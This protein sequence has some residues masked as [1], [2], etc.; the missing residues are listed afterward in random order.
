MLNY[1]LG[2]I[3]TR[4]SSLDWRHIVVVKNIGDMC[5]VSAQ[6][7]ECGYLFPLYLYDADG[8]RRYNMKT[9]LLGG[10][11]P[12]EFFAYA[13]AVLHSPAYRE[14]YREFLKID[15]PRI[16]LPEDETEYQRLAALGQQLIDLHLMRAQQP[17]SALPKFPVA[18]SNAVDA[19]KFDNGKVFINAAQYFDGVSQTAWEFFIGGYQPAKKWLKDRKGRTLSL[20]DIRHYQQVVAILDKT[21]ALMKEIG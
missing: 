4:Q 5:T 16:P 21:A 10:R 9:E 14:K 7:R 6:S 11:N 20:D 18:G 13:Y 19:L 8:T 12:E 2:L 3:I 1:N 17:M 15:F